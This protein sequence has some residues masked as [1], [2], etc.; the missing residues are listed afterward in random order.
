MHNLIS[1]RVTQFAYFDQLLGGLAWK[2]RKVLDFG[3]NI[4]TF[5]VGAGDRVDHDDYWCIDLNREVIERGRQAY[6]RAHFVHYDRYSSQYNP[7]GTRHLPIP[8]CGLKFDIIV[9]FSVFTHTHQSEMFELVEHYATCCH[10][11]GCWRL[12]SQTPVMTAHCPIPSCR[13][14]PT[15]AR[16]CSETE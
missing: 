16:C 3:G 6:P 15:C 10:P 1:T 2:G 12:L 13:R 11:Q 14:V 7:H 8:N 5:L 4:G 9:A